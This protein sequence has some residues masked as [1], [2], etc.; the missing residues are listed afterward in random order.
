MIREH[1][2]GATVEAGALPAV[3]RLL[4]VWVPD[5]PVVALTLEHLHR[6]AGGGA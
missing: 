5:W 6:P 4:A 3:P 2:S 1:G